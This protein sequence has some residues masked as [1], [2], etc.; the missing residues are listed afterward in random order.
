[1]S[2]SGQYKSRVVANYAEGGKSTNPGTLFFKP[3]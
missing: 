2:F 1:M 3:K